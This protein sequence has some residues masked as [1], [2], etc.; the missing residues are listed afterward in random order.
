MKHQVLIIG[1]GLASLTAA[2]RLVAKGVTDIGIY[3]PAFGGTPFIAAIDFSLPQ[4]P[5]KDSEELYEQDMIH[6]G[7]GLNNRALVHAMVSHSVETYTFLDELGIPFSRLED[8][9]LR[10][11]HLSGSTV[12]RSLCST[13]GLIGVDMV[14][15]LKD[16]LKKHGVEVHTG[17]KAFALDVQDNRVQSVMFTGQDGS[18]LQVQ[19][20]VCIAGWGGV[21]NLFGTSTYPAD[22]DGRT[23][24]VAYE[25]GVK[26]VD[27]EFLEYEP[28][29][30][31]SPQ[32]AVGEPCP[33][34]M[35][36]EGAQLFNTKNERFLLKVR[37]QGEAG[38]PKTLINKAIWQQV[39]E[40]NGTEHG[41][42][43]VDL[44]MIPVETLKLY[45][46][47]YNR[48]MDNGVDPHTTLVEVAPMAHSFS[49]GILV[50]ADCRSTVGNLY[51]V[52]EAAGGFHG[53][54]RMAGNAAAQAAVSGL[55]AADAV[56]KDLD[57]G[58]VQIG[59]AAAAAEYTVDADV[60]G[61]FTPIIDE[62]AKSLGVYRN[63]DDLARAV[64]TLRGVRADPSLVRDTD[65]RLRAAAVWL[66]ACAALKRTESRGT[67]NRTDYP[68]TDE[69]QAA[70]NV[71]CKEQLE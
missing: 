30:V 59:A 14:N 32:G 52:G 19:C 9:T 55:M 1:S 39:Q 61:R 26:L 21:G 11:R 63:G 6:A 58:S 36:G 16:Y 20:A 37:P 5:A 8:G 2:C 53:A 44:R 17:W 57:T 25:A 15:V 62:A 43:Y 42:C 12:P 68:E 45:P 56:K 65:T 69:S 49:G 60:R 70:S 28:M 51:A 67:Q 48:L 35:L 47:F 46:W 50:D 66:M 24:A 7:Y 34:A 3:A 22:E 27:L 29:V 31:A 64:E 13:K 33:T 23:I 40:G 4:N 71:F 10:Y 18:Q 41:G 54:C 38:A